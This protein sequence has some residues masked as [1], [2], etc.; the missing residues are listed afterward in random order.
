MK[1][2][3]YFPVNMT[4]AYT[5]EM[6]EGMY[7]GD[8]ARDLLNSDAFYN[9]HLYPDLSDAEWQFDDVDWDD[10]VDELDFTAEQVLAYI[11]G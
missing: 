8:V 7:V 2:H 4:V 11:K 10:W 5:V 3:I 9:E 6:P 1:A